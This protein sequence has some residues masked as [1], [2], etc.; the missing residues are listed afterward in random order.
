M[1]QSNLLT[2]RSL[3]FDRAAPAE[4]SG[5]VNQYVG[6]HSL[7]LPCRSPSS[8]KL[9]HTRF[10]NLDFCRISYGASARVQSPSLDGIYHL[11]LLLRGKCLQQQDGE[12]RCLEP[13]S[14]LMINP[15]DRVD[16]TYSSDCEKFIVRIPAMV[17]ESACRDVGVMGQ[18]T[19]SPKFVRAHYRLAE[20]EGVAD[21]LALMCKEAETANRQMMVEIH[22]QKILALKLLPLLDASSE[23]GAPPRSALFTRLDQF[24]GEHLSQ[25]LDADW[26]AREAQV[27]L[28]SLYLLFEHEVKL[29]PHQYIRRRRLQQIHARLRDSNHPPRSVTEVAMDYGFYHLGRFSEMYKREFGELPSATLKG[30]NNV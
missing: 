3:I 14:L 12:Q 29:P 19:Q 11:Q 2:D 27:S 24:I 22:Y 20:I 6:N 25:D 21:L 4:V 23:R 7:S 28:R 1:P 17:L 18:G 13:G 10:G 9:N 8:A 16:L 26:L 15:Q 5:Y 30:L